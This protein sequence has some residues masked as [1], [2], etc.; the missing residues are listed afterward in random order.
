MQEQECRTPIRLLVSGF[1]PFG[2]QS[3]NPTQ[4]LCERLTR[5]MR[6]DGFER[7][8]PP[9]QILTEVRSVVLPVTFA[10]AY[11][12]LRDEIRDFVPH[13]VIAFGQ[14]GGRDAIELERVAINC[15]DSNSPDNAGEQPRDRAIVEGGATALFSTL[16]LRA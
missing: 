2:D 8:I 4:L 7:T 6:A 1:E 11:P 15:D 16:P 14:A 9:G 12:R 3:L 10:G 5:E 13:A